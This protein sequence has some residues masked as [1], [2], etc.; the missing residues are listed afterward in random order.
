M[1]KLLLGLV[2]LLIVLGV[3][4]SIADIGGNIIL[5]Y[6]QQYLSENMGLTLTAES[7]TGN[8]VKGYRLNNFALADQS[9]QK[10]LS[11]GYLSGRVNF[12]ALLRGDVRLAE[13][14]LGGMSMDLDSLIAAVKNIKFPE[15]KNDTSAFTL[16]AAPAYADSQNNLPDIPLD[17]FSLRD[18]VFS[19]E[20]GIITINEIGADLRTFD[21]DIDGK[22]ND[23]PVKGVIDM[24]ESSGLTAINRSDITLGKGRVLATGGCINDTLDLHISIED[25]DLQEIT[26]LYPA[27]LKPEDFSGT[28][29]IN[30]DIAGELSSPRVIG[31]IDYKGS[32]IYS[33]P[34]ERISTNI[35]YAN[36]RAGFSN[37]QAN[38]FTVPIQGELA[39]ALRPGENLSVMIKL[40]G[41]DASL[42][43]LD[44]VLGIPELKALSGK[45]DSFSANISG[46]INELS[47]LVNLSAPR[48]A[49]SGRVLTNIRAQM[50][51]TKSDKAN[52]DGKFQFE[53]A[54]GYIQGSVASFLNS[55]K[56]DV[57]AKIVDLDVKRVA[58]MIPDASDYK[59][60]GRITAA[61][62]LKGS[63]NDPTITGSL[64]SPEFSGWE[65]TI[66]KPSINFT[67]AAKTLTL[68][69]TQGT[70]NGM[71][72][73]LSG[74]V[75]P[76]PSD[77]P[78]LN[79][80]ATISMTPA[81]LKAYIPDIDQ[82]AVKGSVNAGLK[83]TG[84]VNNPS[85]SLVASSP[86]LQAMDMLS[87]K[88][89][90]LT[91]ALT[92]DLAKLDK[93]TVNASAKSVTASGITF[94]G[95]NANITKNGDRIILGGLNARSGS[96][97]ITGS[98][99]A[100]ITGKSPL[101]FSF[102]FTDLALAPL[103]ASSGLDLKGNLSG[104]L[105]VSGSTTNPAI[106][107]NAN[108][109]SLSAQGFTFTEI[110]ADISGNMEG[111]KLNKL[112]GEVEGAEISAS[113]T[114]KISPAVALDVA[115]KGEGIKLE[116][117]LP[118]IKDDLSGTA[119]FTFS[120]SGTGTNMTGKGV[121]TS[122]AI[123]AYGVRVTNI[124]LP[125]T[126]SG[127]TFASTGGNA[128]FYGG[129]LKN[130]LTLNT[131]NMKYSDTL[132]VSGADLAGLVNDA[133]PDMKDSVSGKATLKLTTTGT[134]A[135]VSAK[136][137]LTIPA[138]KA[139]GF[140]LT[141]ITLPI[142]Y[143]GN[144]FASSGGSAKLYGG[145]LKNTLTFNVAKM[146]FTDNI[147]ASGV[148]VNALIQ[149]AAGGLDGK[150]TGTGK[151]TMKVNG[152]V[153]DKV[154][155]SG[156]GNFSMGS[157]AITGF[158]WLDVIAKV[159]NTN[160]IK[161]TSVNAPLTLQMG[162]LL[163]K[164]G[165]IANAPKNDPMYRYAKLTKDGTIDFSGEEVTM[166][167]ITESS[168]NYQLINAVQ[169]GS[170]GGLEALFKGGTSNLK[171]GL[172]A[173]LS[174]GITGAEKSASTGD[175]RVVNLRISGK[176]ASPSFS[177]LKIGP[178]TVKPATTTQSADKTSSDKSL[179]D[180]LID[181]AVEVI[182][183]GAKQQ[184]TITTT[185]KISGSKTQT[186]TQSQPQNKSTKQQIEDKVKEEL[187]KG[188][189]KGLGGLFR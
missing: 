48:I 139:Y 122:A 153:K 134:G 58:S 47:G 74:T 26:G 114:V 181:R 161:Y 31:T 12:P 37:I 91:T 188:L 22:I 127:N 169:G 70:L 138:L 16:S 94:T 152:T 180:K 69:K 142:S 184:T 7:V 159:H 109:P 126:Y 150:I 29:D 32:K 148:D 133:A 90:E 98:G 44:S 57:T 81:A 124:T 18:S 92:G 168:I 101:D 97:T 174:G 73:N 151:L 19:S 137:A 163:L 145:T 34:I 157:G 23:V 33:F 9:G 143:S 5:G 84:S 41:S 172:K 76:V 3:I 128:K 123:R 14:S 162:K 20:Y 165:T 104:T 113:G 111:I 40:D 120:L 2:L 102:R 67:Y 28:A 21:I 8:P 72:I 52:V 87:A 88:D 66:T 54:Q 173:F 182:A 79:I 59:L 95:L 77:N 80:S 71:P 64:D 179:K 131:D 30:L 60:S 1:L 49:Y 4:F 83:V 96:G 147:D 68:A 189:Q 103:A 11:A 105:K 63:V 141:N 166:N 15:A 38:I 149:D 6:A 135:N 107:L 136:G 62:N 36:Y 110:L 144:N 154:S 35:N 55:P 85:V 65:Q 121:L 43:G 42:D 185:P 160:G 17:R 175:F 130:T 167:L 156:S 132:E 51:L 176:T 187:R 53:G 27:M 89:I 158:K 177:G 171:D 82:Y 108:V 164:A 155:Y 78:A 24:G 140:S 86:S 118:G 99:M 75:G 100:D 183:P 50:K 129:I 61:L 106:T 116:R 25:L 56:L 170:I 13:I 45:V 112:R 10:L 125:L 178:S 39:A 46:H 117:L 119:D 115:V 146:T 186:P 93:I